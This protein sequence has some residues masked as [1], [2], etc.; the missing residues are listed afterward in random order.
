MEVPVR[1]IT[2]M[3]YSRIEALEKRVATVEE[4][5][6]ESCIG[7]IVGE[8]AKKVA[9]QWEKQQKKLARQQEPVATVGMSCRHKEIN[10]HGVLVERCLRD[11]SFL[12]WT[13]AYCMV[14]VTEARD[15]EEKENNKRAT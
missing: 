2:E 12:V 14:H 5:L 1:D 7:G 11:A 9:L 13:R 4:Q 8:A 6:L 3:L 10:E 15:K